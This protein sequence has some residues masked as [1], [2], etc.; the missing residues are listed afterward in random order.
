MNARVLNDCSL[1]FWK[2]TGKEGKKNTV[3]IMWY[4]AHGNGN[5]RFL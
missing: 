3:L 1:R 5:L 4:T 2:W